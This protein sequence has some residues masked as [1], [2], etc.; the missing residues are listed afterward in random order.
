M[1]RAG[2]IVW[3]VVSAAIAIIGLIGISLDLGSRGAFH[4]RPFG[5]TIVQGV[6]VD[7]GF[8]VCVLFA[9]VGVIGLYQNVRALNKLSVGRTDP[10]NL[11]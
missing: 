3:T 2:I 10:A 4:G 7:S 11:R 8:A 5:F 6:Y 1:R 9:V